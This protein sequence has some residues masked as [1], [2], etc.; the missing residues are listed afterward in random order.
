MQFTDLVEG[1]K[2]QQLL[3]RCL[4]LSALVV[5]VPPFDDQPPRDD[6][7]R[8]MSSTSGLMS[9]FEGVLQLMEIP[10]KVLRASTVADRVTEV[11]TWLA[12]R[13]SE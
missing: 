11:T 13:S 1:E 3:S 12:G 10:Y 7:V 9:S 6:G 5:L 8:L 2:V 4:S